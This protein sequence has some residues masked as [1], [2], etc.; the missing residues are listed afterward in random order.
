MS[1][2]TIVSIVLTFM[3]LLGAFVLEGGE[4]GALL[5]LTAAMIVFGG[6]FGAVG[7]AFPIKDIKRVPEML[8]VIFTS[9]D[10]DLPKLIIYFRDLSMKTRKNGLL[11]IENEFTDE[12]MDPFIKKGLQ[13]VVDGVEPQAIKSILELQ[14]ESISERHRKGFSIFEAMGGFS[15]TMGVLG[16]VMG[17]VHVLGSLSD[18][19]TLGPKI[20]T[21]FIATLYGVGAANVLWLPMCTKLKIS[22]DYEGIEKE[23][24]MEAVLLIQTG[25][26][27][28]TLVDK[29][30]GFLN[31]TEMLRLQE[32][33]KEDLE[34]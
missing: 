33:G 27:P 18:P 2:S 32:V 17:L 29:L 10:A 22:N 21:A 23:L 3:A 7:I 19:S 26:S 5:S 20:A 11:S 28:S 12:K 9:H 15:P 6:T 16:T 14:A 31:K 4:L 30:G 13:L 34:E 1:I 25:I 8:K 24:I